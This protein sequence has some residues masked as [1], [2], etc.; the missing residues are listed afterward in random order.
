MAESSSQIKA[1]IATPP[2]MMGPFLDTSKERFRQL[3]AQ[4][5]NISEK[6]RQADKLVDEL[7]KSWWVDPVRYL[8]PEMRSLIYEIGRNERS[9][10]GPLSAFIQETQDAGKLS[11]NIDTMGSI[12]KRMVRPESERGDYS[13]FFKRYY[14]FIK[15]YPEMMEN[16]GHFVNPEEYSPERYPEVHESGVQAIEAFRIYRVSLD[17]LYQYVQLY[18]KFAYKMKAYMVRREMKMQAYFGGE[19]ERKQRPP[20]KDVEILFHA[21]TNV[22]ALLSEG[23]KTK[24]ELGHETP[25]LGGHQEDVVSF[26]ADIELAKGIVDAFRD[27]VEIAHG[28]MT[29][30][31]V[32]R[33]AR[34]EELI[35]VEGGGPERFSE[36]K[37]RWEYGRDTSQKQLVFKAYQKF[38]WY[39]KKR[40]NPVFLGPQ[41]DFFVKLEPDDVGIVACK[42]DMSQVTEYLVAEEEFRVPV[43]AILSVKRV[44]Y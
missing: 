2:L 37:L 12:L 30:E 42:I 40:Y 39:A 28:R 20:M 29:L 6:E 27:I 32:Q 21:S 24:E 18:I 1:A 4:I 15:E 38:L 5:G 43:S 44:L 8:P 41:I 16:L 31:D 25:G 7:T 19:S 35:E 34:E 14:N 9:W 10:A 11:L 23:F 17:A 22:P 3:E 26:T 33:L 13:D 36:E